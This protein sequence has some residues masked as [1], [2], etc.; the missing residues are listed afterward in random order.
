METADEQEKTTPAANQGDPGPTDDVGP[1]LP[2]P[3]PATIRRPPGRPKKTMLAR[4]AEWARADI[5][6]DTLAALAPSIPPDI[7]D[8]EL[9]ICLDSVY[10]TGAQIA[11]AHGVSL[12]TVRRVQ[13]R[14][15]A[16]I[17]ELRHRSGLILGWMAEGVAAKLV[18]LL[19]LGLPSI[20]CDN[21]ADVAKL[22]AAV[23]ALGGMAQ[24]QASRAPAHAG[25]EASSAR[26]ARLAERASG[27][28]IDG[29]A[30]K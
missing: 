15:K 10:M 3:D 12:P 27:V 11:S 2:D 16:E 7:S 26:V 19:C 4:T 30:T 13:A 28:Q 20:P 6:R 5:E 25:A 8:A 9:S 14:Y 18:K 17:G 23:V 22:S 29:N 1:I 24:R 21:A